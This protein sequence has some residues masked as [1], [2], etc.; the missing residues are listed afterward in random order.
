MIFGSQSSRNKKMFYEN[1]F[2]HTRTMKIFE[3]IFQFL[4]CTM[5]VIQKGNALLGRSMKY[6]IKDDWQES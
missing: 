5:S 6:S 3:D 1:H 2:L 4:G